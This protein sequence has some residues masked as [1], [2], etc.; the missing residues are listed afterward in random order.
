MLDEILVDEFI[1]T[2]AE[3]HPPFA[4]TIDYEAESRKRDEA[5]KRWAELTAADRGKFNNRLEKYH[6]DEGV[7]DLK[8]PS[9]SSSKNYYLL[10]REIAARISA[11]S[12]FE[13]LPIDELHF[14][15]AL[16]ELIENIENVAHIKEL[17]KLRKRTVGN[18][19]NA[20]ISSEDAG[21]LKN[22]M[23]QGR[24][25][26]LSGKLGS[27]MVK[28]LN[29]FYSLTAYAYAIV[30][31]NNPIRY[32]LDGLPGSHGINYLPDGAKT[33]FGGDMPHGTFSDLFAAFPTV[34]LRNHQFEIT[35]DCKE[36]L[37]EFYRTRTTVSPGTL[38]S[39]IPELREYYKLITGRNSRAH[40][41]ELSITNDTRTVK[42]EFQIGD[43]E[44]R[45]PVDGVEKEFEGFN[46][47]ERHGKII[48]AVP[49]SDAHRIRACIYSDAR[50][51]FWYI[52][53]PFFPI[54]LPEVC[55]HFLLSNSFSNIMRYS[56][57]R[58]GNILLNEAD[59]NV[60]LIARKY[61]SAFENKFPFLV[62]RSISRFQPYV[63]T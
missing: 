9:V 11:E 34:L 6:S 16:M 62:L 21:R 15:S 48:V 61:L 44:L 22:C 31:L 56:P 42:W 10:Q 12:L 26:Y 8:A 46:V 58:W 63:A 29:F 51:R 24:E 2:K 20:G 43:G 30:I 40:P 3:N 50:G 55:V 13:P 19:K 36:S 59:S 17:Y 27:L 35:Q 39:M 41:L 57:D 33:Q 52:E 18:S 1:T 54:V 37:I 25:L 28:P 45:P 47:Y 14:E 4:T 53:N 7:I 38:L 5:T 23:R 49:G 32:S 60:S